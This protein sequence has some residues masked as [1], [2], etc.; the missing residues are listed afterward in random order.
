MSARSSPPR[1][2]CPDR[3]TGRWPIALDAGPSAPPWRGRHRRRSGRPAR[4][5]VGRRPRA[6][7]TGLQPVPGRL[8]AEAT[9]ADRGRTAGAVSRLLFEALE[10]ACVVA[11][12][13]AGTV[14]PTVGSALVELGYDRDFDRDRIGPIGRPRYP[15]PSGPGLVADR[16][17][18]RCPHR[19]RSAR[20]PRRPRGHGQGPGRRPVGPADRPVL[21]GCGV[22]STWAAM[23]RCPGLP[24]RGGG[25]SGIAAECTAPTDAVGPVVAVA[26]ADWPH[27]GRRPAPGCGTANRAS[28]R[29][30]VDRGGGPPGVVLVS[31]TGA[32]LR[33]G[34]CLE[35]GRGGVG[36]RCCRQPRRPRRHRSVGRRGRSR[37]PRRRWPGARGHR[38][39]RC[40]RSRVR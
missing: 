24:T 27:R 34:Q 23:C 28:H 21:R 12:Q 19:G 13:T 39:D 29:R 25:A 1:S 8:G 11:V 38:A 40:D 36:R 5:P 30:P 9:R 22:W 35:H 14:D 32:E 15:A 4:G 26:P 33:G 31:V 17:G 20:G 37:R 2:L 10:V 7:S 6:P 18:S 16:L 3:A